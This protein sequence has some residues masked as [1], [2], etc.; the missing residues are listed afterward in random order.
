MDL[1]PDIA[2]QM[3]FTSFGAQP[4]ARKRKYN[5]AADA[6]TNHAATINLRRSGKGEKTRGGRGGGGDRVNG[7]RGGSGSNNTPLGWA[8]GKQ[9]P[10]DDR[11]DEEDRAGQGA[12]VGT[13]ARSGD[14]TTSQDRGAL[15]KVDEYGE[16]GYMDDTPPG[17]PLAS[18]EGEHTQPAEAYERR[19]PIFHPPDSEAHGTT[20]LIGEGDGAR[21]LAERGR[22]VVSEVQRQP[23][24]WAVLRR[25][26]RNEQGDIAY[27]DQ[28]FVEDPW[29][30]L[31]GVSGNGSERS[32]E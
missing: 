4:T 17:S 18:L 16:P 1:D 9:G 20:P 5:S 31:K 12:V 24:D 22:G 14:K 13:E 23:Y 27:Y 25:G 10:L 8:R 29:R 2:F 3:G 30:E 11:T 19:P 26:V 32:A 15:S 6:V 7:C 21:T 28:S